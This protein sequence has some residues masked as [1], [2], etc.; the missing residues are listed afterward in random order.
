MKHPP[1]GPAPGTATEA[2]Y[3]DFRQYQSPSV[4]EHRARRARRIGIKRAVEM[5]L[6]NPDAATEL[7]EG[8]V[9]A[10][11][12][13]RAWADRCYAV[14]ETKRNLASMR[15]DLATQAADLRFLSYE[16]SSACQPGRQRL[17]TVPQTR[18]RERRSPAC[19][20]RR[21]KTASSSTSG[22][23]DSDPPDP[24]ET[25]RRLNARRPLAAN[26][27]HSR[28]GCHV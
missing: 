5:L 21:V 25:R 20:T 28:G 17:R 11:T 18:S 23:S 3:I 12:R 27:R 7:I 22:S 16:S 26:H 24:D 14:A 6:D 4:G 15:E 2:T 9:D 19:S 13:D 10:G 1:P 8:W